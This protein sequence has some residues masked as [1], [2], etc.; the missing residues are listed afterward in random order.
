MLGCASAMY[1]E[2]E[3]GA[4]KKRKKQLAAKWTTLQYG[5]FS[6]WSIFFGIM[7]FLVCGN[8]ALYFKSSMHPV[9]VTGLLGYLAI[10]MW[11]V[12]AG[13]SFWQW[14]RYQKVAKTSKI[15]RGVRAAGGF[16][17]LNDLEQ[18]GGDEWGGGGG[19]DFYGSQW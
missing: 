13:G 3:S 17:A 11:L 10:V 6:T 19:Y 5:C 9:P 14:R 15:K 16:A 7:V 2:M 12:T 8:F 1:V 18:E 4:G